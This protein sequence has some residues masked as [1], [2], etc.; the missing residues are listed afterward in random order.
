M[1]TIP[2]LEATAPPSFATEREDAH[3]LA[4]SVV[5]EARRLAT[6]RFGLRWTPGG[7]GTP[8]FDGDRQVRIEGT[9][10][11]VQKGDEERSESITTLA[12]AGRFVGLEPATEAAESDS[13]TLGELDR[14]LSLGADTM[15][16]L[17]AWFGLG[18]AVLEELR[19]DP[20]SHDASTTQLW[21][22]HFDPAVEIGDEALGRRATFGASPGDHA[23]EHPYLYVGPW[24]EID[25]AD[26]FWNADTFKGAMLPFADLAAAQDQRARALEF[27]HAALHRLNT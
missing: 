5:A 12:A 3:R 7:F 20:R 27:F 9:S 21:P 11:V 13:P 15:R 1:D 18:W 14:H 4:Y 17:D 22:G 2:I 24:G 8:V 16:L 25:S 19:A 23:H 6:G 26:G 10:L